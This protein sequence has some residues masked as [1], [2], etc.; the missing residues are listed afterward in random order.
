MQVRVSDI[1]RTMMGTCE[2]GG[3][4]EAGVTAASWAEVWESARLVSEVWGKMWS[5]VSLKL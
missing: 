4:G 2:G 5:S 3:V 1:I